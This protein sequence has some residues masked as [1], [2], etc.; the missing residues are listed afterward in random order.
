MN[1]LRRAATAHPLT[2]FVIAAYAFS[3]W[4][5]PFANAG[6]L[7]YGPFVA[8]VLII[9][10]TKGRSGLRGL[11]RRMTSWQGGLIW[12]LIA[13]GLVVL[14]LALAFIANLLL[15]GSVSQTSH[16][17]SFGPTLL[18]LVL[19]GGLWEEPGWTGF[20]LPLLQER[21]AGRPLG[22]LRASIITGLIRAG[23]HLPLMI[24]GAIPW[25]DVLFFSMAF[26]FM[27]S[28][29]SNR[30]GGSVLIPMVFHLTS[31]VVAGGLVIPLFTGPDH[32]RYYVLL[33]ALAWL[34]ALLLNRPNK[35]SMGHLSPSPGAA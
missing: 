26:Q 2:W 32:D 29:L 12:L 11:L 15:G 22:L 10:L 25:F 24:S 35:W 1:T 18:S 28:W 16:L 20:A 9:G 33:V 34:P 13:P 6:I 23:W 4:V 7:P 27:I 31:N 8:A 30:T 17:A 14:Y 3:W 21:N 5:I 19:L